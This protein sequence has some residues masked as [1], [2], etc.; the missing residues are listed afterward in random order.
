MPAGGPSE[1][2]RPPEPAQRCTMRPPT[3]SSSTRPHP[4]W[5]EN[6]SPASSAESSTD[7][8]ASL[9][10]KSSAEGAAKGSGSKARRRCGMPPAR[11]HVCSPT[12][13]R[14][15]ASPSRTQPRA[16]PATR[17]WTVACGPSTRST[18]TTC[19]PPEPFTSTT[20]SPTSTGTSKTRTATTTYAPSRAR[21]MTPCA[22][23]V[24]GISPYPHP[25]DASTLSTVSS[26]PARTGAPSSSSLTRSA[27]R[28]VSSSLIS[29]APLD[30]ALS[31]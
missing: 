14:Y 10:S 2:T 4:A 21:G 27:T 30:E 25:V 28:P 16:F 12:C 26:S 22:A 3:P 15:R 29:C 11:G 9:R 1:S 6:S 19:A 17:T 24:H 5:T 7:P 8:S 31:P 13:V 18:G 23:C 20:S